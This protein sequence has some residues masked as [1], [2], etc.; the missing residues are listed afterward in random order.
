MSNLN[1][2]D[3]GYTNGRLYNCYFRELEGLYDTAS[4]MITWKWFY[5]SSS[6]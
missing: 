4:L 6:Y 1:K 5:Y 3:L 2:L